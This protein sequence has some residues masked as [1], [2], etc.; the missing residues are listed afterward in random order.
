MAFPSALLLLRSATLLCIYAFEPKMELFPF[1]LHP[2]YLLKQGKRKM[3]FLSAYIVKN[4]PISMMGPT[5]YSIVTVMC[6]YYIF[7][8]L[9]M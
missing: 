9:Y 3:C 2:L 1:P 7:S 8:E 6:S 4:N 5:S